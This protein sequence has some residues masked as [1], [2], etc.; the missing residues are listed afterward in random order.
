MASETRRRRRAMER[1]LGFKAPKNFFSKEAIDLR[2]R[3]KKA[4]EEVH[5]QNLENAKNRKLP[6]K[7][8]AKDTEVTEGIKLNVDLTDEEDTFSLDTTPYGFLENDITKESK[9]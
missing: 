4:G 3:K 8:E 9:K 6:V 7:V 2:D 1:A 5:R